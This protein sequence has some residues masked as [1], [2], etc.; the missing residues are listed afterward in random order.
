[1]AFHL[2]VENKE[3][4]ELLSQLTAEME[5]QERVADE[6][7]NVTSNHFFLTDNNVCEKMQQ[8][9]Y[10]IKNDPDRE[11]LKQDVM[12][13]AALLLRYHNDGLTKEVAV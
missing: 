12:E 9:W 7:N 2:I 10:A 13:M 11:S 3:K 5:V 8:L 6:L 4:H 1:M